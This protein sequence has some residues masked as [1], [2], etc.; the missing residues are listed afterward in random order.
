MEGM[1]MNSDF[2]RRC[3]FAHHG[4]E[5]KYWGEYLVKFGDFF[6]F[7]YFSTLKISEELES[8]L[9]TWSCTSLSKS[10]GKTLLPRVAVY[11]GEAEWKFTLAKLFKPLNLKKTNKHIFSWKYLYIIGFEIWYMLYASLKMF[12]KRIVLKMFWS[13]LEPKGLIIT[14]VGTKA[15]CLYIFASLAVMCKF[16]RTKWK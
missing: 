8:V 1:E 6:V 7:K 2:W 15:S 4:S 14:A 12:L 10:D 3:W 9:F 5:R 16:S 11:L 13:G